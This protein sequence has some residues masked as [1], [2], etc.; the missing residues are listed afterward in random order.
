MENENNE[1]LVKENNSIN[2]FTNT[3]I[4]EPDVITNITDKKL[5]YNLGKRVDKLLNDC[6]GEEIEIDKILI[7]KYQKKLEEPIV[8]IETGEIISDTKTSL[9]VVIVD[10]S[11]TSYATGSKRFGYSLINAIN[12]FQ[13]EMCGMKIRI[14]KTEVSGCQN[15]C[16]D[17]EIL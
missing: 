14:I 11:G 8:N 6:V 5:M 9:S 7:K 3:G 15:K 2:T 13:E 4:T 17:F 16:L 1:L 10:K 12:T